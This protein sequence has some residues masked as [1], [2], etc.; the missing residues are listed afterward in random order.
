MEKLQAE[1]DCLKENLQKKSGE[2][3]SI[4]KSFR[5]NIQKASTTPLDQET[6]KVLSQLYKKRDDHTSNKLFVPRK[7]YHVRNSSR[8]DQF[9]VEQV[10]EKDL[11]G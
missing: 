10:E 4:D 11:L 8:A 6:V 9:L 5:K 7:V 2:D 1:L 3:K